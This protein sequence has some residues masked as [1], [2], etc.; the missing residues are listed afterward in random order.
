RQLE[1]RVGLDQQLGEGVLDPEDQDGE[2]G[3]PDAKRNIV[4]APPLTGLSGT[5]MRRT[6]GQRMLGELAPGTRGHD[7]LTLGLLGHAVLDRSD[8]GGQDTAA[9]QP[10]DTLRGQHADIESA[11]PRGC[12]EHALKPWN[13]PCKPRAPDTTDGAGND[14]A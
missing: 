12:G 8:D 7:V 9:D 2:N 11:T 1:R 6:L 5:L 4:G 10:T 3:E 14:V 13:E